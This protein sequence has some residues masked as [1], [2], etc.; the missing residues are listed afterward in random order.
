[1]D[2]MQDGISPDNML[3][4]NE[5]DSTFVN[6]HTSGGI[7][8][9]K[10]LL[11]KEGDPNLKGKKKVRSYRLIDSFIHWHSSAILKEQNKLLLT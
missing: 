11:S 4:D 5:S 2:D 3:L 8:P 10:L 6:K 7:F 1:M 9:I